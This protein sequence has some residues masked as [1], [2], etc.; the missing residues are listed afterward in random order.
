MQ[1]ISYNFL[2]K[3][4]KSNLR[5]WQLC[6]VNYSDVIM[7]KAPSVVSKASKQ[8]KRTIENDEDDDDEFVCFN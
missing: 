7:S 6:V 8:S 2:P 5:S 1:K 3:T 4:V